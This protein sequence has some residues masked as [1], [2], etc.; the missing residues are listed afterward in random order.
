MDM[1]TLRRSQAVFQDSTQPEAT[2]MQ[3][4]GELIAAYDPDSHLLPAAR[5][6]AGD[7]LARALEPLARQAARSALRSASRDQREQLADDALTL[8][9]DV[10]ANTQRPR[11]CRFNA[12]GR[13]FGSLRKWLRQTL[14]R[15]WVSQQRQAAAR[16]ACALGELDPA[17]SNQPIEA[18]RDGVLDPC[19]PY[20]PEDLA[21]L[22]EMPVVMRV[23]TLAVAVLWLKVPAQRWET[24]VRA[25]ERERQRTLAR[26]FPPRELLW[27]ETLSKRCEI[28]ARLLD[29]A[30]ATLT[31]RWFRQLPHW[32]SRLACY[33]ELEDG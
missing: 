30:P 25:Y 19:R 3:A 8:L 17:C 32:F 22:E 10:S 24:W 15:R 5:K 23:E 28:L 7:L 1:D 20:A 14:Y 2:R 6:Q 27:Q 26:P 4:L 13:T 31:Q 16:P 29:C 9:F 21:L 18:L 12:S 33:R 11:I